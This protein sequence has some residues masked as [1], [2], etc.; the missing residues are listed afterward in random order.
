[1]KTNLQTNP[2]PCKKTETQHNSTTL[3]CK[4]RTRV[5]N[6]KKNGYESGVVK[7]GENLMERGENE[8][9]GFEEELGWP[10]V[11][12]NGVLWWVVVVWG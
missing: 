1:V 9:W 7:V 8:K 5:K 4:W 2:T 10:E 6:F 11:V 3:L 12:V